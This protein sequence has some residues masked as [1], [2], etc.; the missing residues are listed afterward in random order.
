MSYLIIEKQGIKDGLLRW[1][2]GKEPAYLAGD[3]GSISGS[4]RA[5]GEGNDNPL[6]NS[7]L[8][9]LMD[10]GTWWATIHGVSKSWTQLRG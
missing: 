7:C 2:S 9:N 3:T 4:E 6:Q 5:P 8:E 1:L 10:T